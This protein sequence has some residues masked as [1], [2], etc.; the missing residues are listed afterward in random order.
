MST[1]AFVSSK[2]SSTPIRSEFGSDVRRGLTRSGQKEL[3]SKYFY[4]DLGTLLFQA[5]T[6]LPE[7]GLTRADA[8]ILRTNSPA[9]IRE[10]GFP[11]LIAELGSGT[12]EKTRFLLE[13]V[14]SEMPAGTRYCP[15]DVSQAALNQCERELEQFAEVRPI[16]GSYLPGIRA[17]SELRSSGEHLLVLFLGSTLGNFELPC[18]WEF[19]KELRELLQPGDYLL[20][21]VDLIKPVP[22]LI[23]AYDDAHGITAAFNLNILSRVNSELGANFDLRHFQHEARYNDQ[24]QRIEMHLRSKVAQRVVIPGAGCVIDFSVGETIWTESSHKYQLAQLDE[25]A[26]T[27]G[28][29]VKSQWT[30][31]EWPFVESLWAA[32]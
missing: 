2:I 25:M 31:Q 13:V 4:D 19:L 12:G 21:G 5:I 10:A 6:L 24:K 20:I 23:A 32:V 7:Y 26:S 16:L 22:Q 18:A 28:F 29:Q 15:I 17:A 30:D 3:H 9:I 27:N 1:Q 11:T 14:S 8:R